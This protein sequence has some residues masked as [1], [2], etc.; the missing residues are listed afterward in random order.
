MLAKKTSK[1]ITVVFPSFKEV[2]FSL[3]LIGNFVRTELY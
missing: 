3:E 2:E 1:G